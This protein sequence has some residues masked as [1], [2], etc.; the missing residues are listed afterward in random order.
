MSEDGFA[1][2][3]DRQKTYLRLVLTHANSGEIARAEAE[4]GA[5]V[6][7]AAIDKVIRQAMER[8]GATSRF[9]A[10]RMLAEYEDSLGVRRSD[11]ST[12]DLSV[13][14]PAV[15][16]GLPLQEQREG[17][18]DL[19]PIALEDVGVRYVP[20]PPVAGVGLGLRPGASAGTVWG[21]V[22][23]SLLITIA[24]ALVTI[25]LGNVLAELSH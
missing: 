20:A 17:L 15:P 21:R 10:A 14:S 24:L 1:K 2:L 12:S 8:I 16:S 25:A 11:L 4:R 9:Q 7:K 13:P 3:T 23:R 5:S 18:P 19:A 22:W 6:S